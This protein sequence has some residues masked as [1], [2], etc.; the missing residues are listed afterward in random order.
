M[1][2]SIDRPMLDEALASIALQTWPRI[3]VVVVA[4]RPGH[5][6]LPARCGPFDLR[7]V[8]ADAPLQ[9]SAA[10]NRALDHARGDYLL[11]LDDDDWLMPGHIARLADVLRK[12]PKARVAYTGVAL[13]NAA[14]EPMGQAMDLPFDGV[15][16]L[17]GNITPIH[18]VLFERALCQ[19]PASAR[20][21]EQVDHYEDWDF[22]LQLARRST[23]VHLPGVSAFY[24]VHDS[25]GVHADSG[26]QS[27]AAATIFDKWQGYWTK[28]QRGRLMERA[29][30]ADDLQRTLA[31]AQ[32]AVADLQRVTADQHTI[33]ARQS[34]TLAEQQ[35]TIARQQGAIDHQL[36][37]LHEQ[38]WQ[39]S[40]LLAQSETQAAELARR[41][42]QVA[43]LLG[44]TSWKI[45][46]PLRRL[47]G[48]LKRR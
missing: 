32:A 13:V 37:T 20:F 29:W 45:T 24:R 10:A 30:A 23:F 14:G 44:S 27:A 15:R 35:A 41:D 7:L 18:A 8:P 28:E 5:R 11:F 2:R 19:G 3:E 4:A 46:A 17:A 9:R 48:A 40:R 33:L 6:E 43:D 31:A 25:S 39:A 42:A 12:Q 36:A 47:S 22:W 21:D 34:T 26:P 16:Q 38:A 1:V